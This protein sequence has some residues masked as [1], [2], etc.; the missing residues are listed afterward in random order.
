MEKPPIAF[1][2]INLSERIQTQEKDLESNIASLS[3]NIESLPDTKL[4]EAKA[5]IKNS[6]DAIQ[7]KIALMYAGGVIL[8]GVEALGMASAAPDWANAFDS[9]GA[10]FAS[11]ALPAALL[12][13]AATSINWLNKR[14]ADLELQSN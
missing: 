4:A 2:N 14:M 8:S 11:D 7:E 3:S 13:L 1:E 5:A 6:F 12:A 10:T 9:A